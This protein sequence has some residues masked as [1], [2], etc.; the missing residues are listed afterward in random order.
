M[1]EFLA[2]IV[3]LQSLYIFKLMCERH[4]LDTQLASL[5]GEAMRR[6][7]KGIK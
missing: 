3:G 5:E 7:S 1:A 2:M 4:E 6:Y